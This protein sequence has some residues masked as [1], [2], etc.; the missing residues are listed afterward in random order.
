M[1]QVLLFGLFLA[2]I[3]GVFFLLFRWENRQN[4]DREL[5]AYQFAAPLLAFVY[6]LV[7]NVFL[8]DISTLV[9]RFLQWLAS[10]AP[11]LEFLTSAASGFFMILMNVLLMI[12]FILI[13]RIFLPLFVKLWS[14]YVPLFNYTSGTCYE[15][16]EERTRWVLKDQYGD[17]RRVLKWMRSGGCIVSFGLF[18]LILYINEPGIWQVPFYP[19]LGLMVLAEIVYFMDGLT[20]SEARTQVG[21]EDEVSLFRANYARLRVVLGRIFPEAM[22]NGGAREKGLNHKDGSQDYLETLMASEDHLRK[23]CGTYFQQLVKKGYPVDSQYVDATLHILNH[24]SVLFSTPFYRDLTVYLFFAIN[25]ALMSHERVLIICGRDAII[26]DVIE[27]VKDA[28]VEVSHLPFLWNVGVLK[29]QA[30]APDVGIL[31]ISQIFDLSLHES[32]KAFFADVTHVVLLEPSRIVATAQTALYMLARKLN[33]GTQF[34]IFDKNSDGLVDALSHILKTSIIEVNATKSGASSSQFVMWDADSRNMHHK[35]FPGVARYLGVGSEVAMVSLKY[36]VRKVSWY[37][38]D[39]FPVVDMKWIAGQ[40][41]PLICDYTGIPFKQHRIGEVLEFV[42]NLWGAAQSREACVVVED[43]YHNLFEMARQFFTRGRDQSF[44]HVIA[45]QY[46][47]REYMNDNAEIFIRDPKAIPSFAPDFARTPRNVVLE[48]IMRMVISPVRI[49]EV[50]TQLELLFGEVEN[51]PAFLS[52]QIR[53]YFI[54]DGVDED[55]SRL[56]QMKQV[57]FYDEITMDEEFHTEL[58]IDD[59]RFIDTYLSDLHNAGYVAEDEQ[60][61]HFLGANLLGQICQM[62]LPGQF[63]TIAGKYYEVIRINQEKGVVLRR[64]ADHIH[65]RISYRQIR[66]YTLK[67]SGAETKTVVHD[68]IEVTSAAMNMTADTA[69]FL[70]M[71]GHHDMVN[72]RRVLLDDVPRRSYVRKTVLRLKLPKISEAVRVTLCMLLNEIFRTVYPDNCDYL[73]A[74]TAL[75]S[76]EQEQLEGIVHPLSGDIDPES[77]YILEDSQLDLGMIISIER[78]L[79]RMLE[80]VCDYLDWHLERLTRPDETIQQEE[81]QEVPLPIPP[82]TP[83]NARQRLSYRFKRWLKRV[84]R[85]KKKENVQMDETAGSQPESTEESGQEETPQPQPNAYAKSHYLLFGREEMLSCLDLEETWTYLKTFGFDHN[86]LKEARENIHAAKRND[87]DPDD[88]HRCD[89]CARSLADVDYEVLADGRERCPECSRTAVHTV[90]EFRHIYDITI[91][92]YEAFFGVRITAAIKLEMVNANTLHRKLGKSF[93]PSA[94]YSS[95]VLGVAIRDR[96]GN[97]TIYV[98]NGAPRNAFIATLVHELTHIWQYTT[99]NEKELMARYG[100]DLMPAVYEGMAKWVE[101]QYMLL[102]GEQAHARREE[103]ITRARD[104]EYGRGFLYYVTRYPL[105]TTQSTLRTPFEH[106]H[107]PLR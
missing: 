97:Y 71:H 99:W 61:M 95:R 15:W 38:Y 40:Y 41:Y 70:E 46:L 21:G 106:I 84:F 80:I 60:D 92:N 93:V 66:S 19:V 16:E 49:E 62:Y 64:A 43:E 33:E 52:E 101:I 57:G 30:S 90:E 89:F 31:S 4:L 63:I 67:E 12:G 83:K 11:F 42:P 76:E 7:L 86:I 8:D 88:A 91:Q 13:K 56:I 34:S 68:G 103:L 94:G 24:Q 72:A 50:R 79:E 45:P 100:G 26:D 98:E 32:N 5:R 65:G 51:I 69:G 75:T 29:A 54:S 74:S 82:N 73:S 96:H 27:W 105:S 85:R 104:D 3:Y 17:M 58:Y 87:F 23:L 59:Q 6:A 44:V 18:A 53:L 78:N 14:R 39:S 9:L 48:L 55:L 36:G 28:V 1:R 2:G 10:M 37:A 22:L 20:A 47:L 35:L 25:R 102:I 77:I 81:E 107:E